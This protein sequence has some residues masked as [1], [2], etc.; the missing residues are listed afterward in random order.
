MTLS[1]PNAGLGD[2]LRR[3]RNTTKHVAKVTVNVPPGDELEVSEYVAEQAKQNSQIVDADS[4]RAPYVAPVEESDPVAEFEADDV[5]PKP[6]KRA[7]KKAA[8]K[9]AQD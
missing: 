8:S 9:S 3:L 2:P 7:A 5:E 4:P 1:T 6:R